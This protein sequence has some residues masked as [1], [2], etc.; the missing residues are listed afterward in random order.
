MPD[1]TI[2]DDA[3]F[4]EELKAELQ[5]LVPDDTVSIV[6]DHNYSE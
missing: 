2:H 4:I 6:I 5:P 3:A 1:I